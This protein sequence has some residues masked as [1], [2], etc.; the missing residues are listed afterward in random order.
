MFG[1][2]MG[3]PPAKTKDFRGTLI[4]LF[5]F[6]RPEAWGLGWSSCSPWSASSSP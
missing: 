2:G 1:M 6:L 5:G 3:L 4:R